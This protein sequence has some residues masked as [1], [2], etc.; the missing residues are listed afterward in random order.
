MHQQRLHYAW[1]VLVFTILVMMAGAGVRNAIGTFVHPWEHEFSVSRGTVSMVATLS[2]VLFGLMQPVVGRWADRRGPGGVL[3]SSL[4]VIAIGAL[5]SHYARS[6]WQ[7]A[8]T[9]GLVASLGFAGVSNV[10]GFVAV[11]RW[12]H[13]RRG[14][15]I[16]L[17]T[18]ASSLGT[19]TITPATLL[20]NDALGWRQTVVIYAAGLALLA[21]LVYWLV[22]PD[23]ANVGQSPYGAGTV[24]VPPA[25]GSRGAGADRAGLRG[26]LSAPNFWWLAL[27]YFACGFTTLGLINTHLVPFAQDHHLPSGATATAVTLLALFNST[28]GLV[29]GYLS[30][31]MPRRYLLAFLYSM[32]AVTLLF[33]LTVSSPVTLMVFAVL[34]GLVDIATVPPT[35]SLTAEI[36]GSGRMGVVFGLISLSHQAGSATGALVPGLLYDLTGGY[37]VSFLLG[38]GV[39]VVAT[40]L[41]LRI[42]EQRRG[43]PQAP[44]AVSAGS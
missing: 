21:P 37:Q 13:A 42:G 33:L 16:A 27:P 19:M 15:A 39:L 1:V 5:L 22:K 4:L 44:V 26:V 32:R 2:F 34:F 43:A 6:M 35:S 12:F 31:R 7:V 36:F 20:L 25:H 8:L 3:A 40:L 14:L 41:S 9:F 38:A 29:S 18:F 28:G 24:P 30:D 23:P 11:A 10:P 17:V